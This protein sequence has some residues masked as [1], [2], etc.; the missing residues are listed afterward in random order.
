MTTRQAGEALGVAVRTVQLWVEAGVLPAWRTAGGHRRIARSAVEQL[1]AERA[2]V[3]AHPTMKPHASA[4]TPRA[5][6]LL[7]VEHD[8]ELR[9]R[10]CPHGRRLGLP[11]RV[12]HRRQRL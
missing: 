6:K 7:L 10:F 1:M 8:P 3:I 2:L 5:L 9:R 11:R 12:D 4:E